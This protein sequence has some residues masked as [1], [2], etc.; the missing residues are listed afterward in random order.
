MFVTV[1]SLILFLVANVPY[2]ILCSNLYLFLVFGLILVLIL[3]CT[4]RCI[5]GT[6]NL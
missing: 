5:K 1:D 3:Y 6:R 4:G 2:F